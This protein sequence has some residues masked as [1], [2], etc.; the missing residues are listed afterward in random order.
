MPS[1][2][3]DEVTNF[4]KTWTA[5]PFSSSPLNDE[6]NYF[7]PCRDYSE[8]GLW[9]LD[10]TK[11][12]PSTGIALIPLLLSIQGPISKSDKMSYHKGSW[13]LDAT[14]LVVLIVALPWNLTG[15]SAA[16]LLSTLSNF[17]V[18]RQ[19]QIQIPWLWDFAW[20]YNKT[21]YWILRQDL[22]LQT[23]RVSTFVSS[24]GICKN[25]I[26]NNGLPEPMLTQIYI[27]ILHH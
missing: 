25:E 14:R 5:V 10:D 13:N 19:Y 1:K 23:G 24:E 7:N 21:F 16:V 22:G 27:T 17:R 2:V 15:T 8:R 18:T 20:F 4:S 9:T 12:K 3:W 11:N 26:G 6:C